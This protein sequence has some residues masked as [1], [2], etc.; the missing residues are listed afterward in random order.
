MAGK[1]GGVGAG[2]V[3]GAGGWLRLGAHLPPGAD[4]LCLWE[5]EEEEEGRW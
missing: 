3:A 1:E 2:G 5:N 4:L